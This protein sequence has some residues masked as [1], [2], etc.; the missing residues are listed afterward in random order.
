MSVTAVGAGGEFQVTYS[1]ALVDAYQDG[2]SAL[3]VDNINANVVQLGALAE[4]LG[5]SG[6]DPQFPVFQTMPDGSTQGLNVPVT[7]MGNAAGQGLPYVGSAWVSAGQWA[8]A[9]PTTNTRAQVILALMQEQRWIAAQPAQV[10]AP[11]RAG[12]IPLFV[13]GA[14][15]VCGAAVAAYI[16][17]EVRVLTQADRERSAAWSAVAAEEGRR[18][19]TIRTTGPDPGP[20]TLDLGLKLDSSR[21]LPH[22][23]AFFRRRSNAPPPPR[24]RLHPVKAHRTRA[25]RTPVDVIVRGG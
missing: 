3:T 1:A 2:T 9:Q 22:R 15:V 13:A 20:G 23:P 17:H 16:V 18:A 12:A 19:D 6:T 21:R 7:P 25:A 8:M 11:V 14:L 4:T 24:P 5:L 10:A